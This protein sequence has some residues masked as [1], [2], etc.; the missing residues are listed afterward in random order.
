MNRC[1]WG[2]RRALWASASVDSA[3][4]SMRMFLRVYRWAAS[5]NVSRICCGGGAAAQLGHESWMP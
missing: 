3:S 1:M 5:A 2:A 4:Y